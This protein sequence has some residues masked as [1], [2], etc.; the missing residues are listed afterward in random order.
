MKTSKNNA[1]LKLIP[2]SP[3]QARNA[4]HMP[5]TRCPTPLAL[6][7][8]ENISPESSGRKNGQRRPKTRKSKACT[9]LVAIHL[10]S[11][12]VGDLPPVW[13][14]M[15]CEN[16]TKA[17]APKH[18]QNASLDGSTSALS[19]QNVEECLLGLED[20]C[21]ALEIIAETFKNQLNNTKANLE[22]ITNHVG[23]G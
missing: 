8:T 15:E 23:K 14:T 11:N 20:F 1:A 12:T 13:G 2:K 6:T 10:D 3:K 4:T 21:D 5:I 18:S 16:Q 9:E 17:P 19:Q 22:K 7:E